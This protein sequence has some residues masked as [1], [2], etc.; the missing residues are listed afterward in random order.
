MLTNKKNIKTLIIEDHRII[1]EAYSSILESATAFN[2]DITFAINCDQAINTLKLATQHLVLL[3]LQVPASKNEKFISGEDI[4][5]W[6]RK[7]HPNTKIIILTF[8]SD[9]FRISNIIKTINPEGFIIKSDIKPIDLVNAA[10]TILDNKTYYSKTVN[11]NNNNTVNGHYID[12]LDRKILY[13]LSMG[14][15]TKDLPNLVHIALRTIEDRKAKLKDIFGIITNVNSNLIKE[16][17]RH[18]I[19]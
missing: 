16:A 8:V 17:K 12:D 7:Y 6:L 14:E 2:F 1:A 13:H 9:Y 18:H 10:Q 3:D 11:N 5:L 19:I 15:K 4:G